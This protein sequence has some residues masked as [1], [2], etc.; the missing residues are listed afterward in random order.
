MFGIHPILLAILWSLTGIAS[1]NYGT[2]ITFTAPLS[3][4]DENPPTGFPGT[5]LTASGSA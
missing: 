3:G 5:G 4:T 1:L 2:T